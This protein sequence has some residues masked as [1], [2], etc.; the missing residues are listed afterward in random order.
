MKE[1]HNLCTIQQPTCIL[2]NSQVCLTLHVEFDDDWPIVSNRMLADTVPPQLTGVLA[3]ETHP[4][5]PIC[6]VVC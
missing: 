5:S 3:G 4:F 6:E 2:S 1:F